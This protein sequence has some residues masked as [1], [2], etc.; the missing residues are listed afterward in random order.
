MTIETHKNAP[1]RVY[2]DASIK[3]DAGTVGA[4]FTTHMGRVIGEYSSRIDATMSSTYAEFEAIVRAL[5]LLEHVNGVEHVKVFGDNI[6]VVGI[7]DP[8]TRYR[9]KQSKMVSYEDRVRTQVE[10][11]SYCTFD[12]IPRD[13]NPAHDVAD[14]AYRRTVGH[15]MWLDAQD[16]RAQRYVEEVRA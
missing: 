8:S 5:S 10:E 16:D 6:S 11:F 7:F 2:V 15:T 14:S 3:G 1:L 9:A 4:V 12:H 13:L